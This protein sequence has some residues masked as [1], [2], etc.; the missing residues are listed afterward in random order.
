MEIKFTIDYSWLEFAC[1][2]FAGMF[3]LMTGYEAGNRGR[4]FGLFYFL[5]AIA[6]TTVGAHL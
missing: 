2:F 3:Y 5:V 4:D 1:H 6:L